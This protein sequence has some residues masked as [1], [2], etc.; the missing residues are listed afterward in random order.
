MKA[1]KHLLIVAAVVL[2]IAITA[3]IAYTVY[4]IIA[5]SS[6]AATAAQ[7]TADTSTTESTSSTTVA[8]ADT[9]AIAGEYDEEDQALTYDESSAVTITLSDSGSVTEGEGVTISGSTVTITQ[10]GTYVISGSLTNGQL[11]IDSADDTTVRIV[12]NGVKLTNDTTVP[13]YVAQAA[14]TILMTAE[15]SE[16]TITLTAESFAD[17]DESSAA[18]YSK[19]DLTLSGSGTLTV[20]TSV[21]NGVQSKDDLKVTGGTYK[22][23]STNEALKGKDSIQI[24]DGTFTIDTQ[25]DGMQTTNTEET[26]KGYIVIDGGTFTIKSANDGIQA[27]TALIIND[28][29]MDI[30]T[31][32]ADSSDTTQSFK[33]LKAAGDILLQGGSYTITSTDDSI[34]SNSNITITGGTYELATGDDGIHADAT[35]TISGGSITITESYEGIE[36][37]NVIITGGEI[38]ITASDDGLNAAGGSV[39]DESTTGDTGRFGA[40]SF[41]SSGDYS[42][43]I[44]GGTITINAQADGLD[45]NGDI[46]MTGGTVLVYGPTDNGNGALDYDGT[47]ELSGGTLAALGSSGMAQ[48][49]SDSSSQASI[50]LWL[51][52]TYSAGETIVLT[53]ASGNE[54]LTVEA[55]KE[56]SNV[57]LSAPELTVGETYTIELSGGSTVQVT[58]DS[59][60]TSIDES[61][62]AAST[63][64]GMGGGQGGGNRMQ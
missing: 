9:T 50:Q 30:Q 55:V 11:Y 53:D 63:N 46:T 38:S 57:V 21:G 13:I 28:A 15:S 33:G 51:D 45:S 49:A 52:S 16:N 3:G 39:N 48:T 44:A 58:L 34:H 19:D 36:G 22:I 14:K 40:D 60:V 5:G 41:Q 37:A 20:L 43:Q 62:N 42:I 24:L 25:S 1:K 59:T 27:A 10:G 12:L 31:N 32:T 18:I 2:A 4:R 47:F 61:G 8:A 23:T 64:Q 56:F 6:G 54:I 29:V 26:D 17:T 35:T 7:S